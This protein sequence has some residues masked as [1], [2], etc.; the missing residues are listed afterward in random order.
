MP[1]IL[2]SYHTLFNYYKIYF[3]SYTILH[4]SLK[5]IGVFITLFIVIA[6]TATDWS[7]VDAKIMEKIAEG[8]FTGCVLGIYTNSSA[9]LKKAYGSTGPRWGL[10]SPS[11]T[12]DSVFDINYLTQVIGINSGIMQLYD[13][14]RVN[15]TDRISKHLFDFDNNGK[16]YITIT[17][18]MVHN[19]GLQAT[20]P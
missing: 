15:F 19:S 16:R 17:N 11:V 5:K 14:Q 6:S 13:Q 8:H 18:I 2:D 1:K 12:V 4:M 9:L 7:K 20:M 10:Y 3:E